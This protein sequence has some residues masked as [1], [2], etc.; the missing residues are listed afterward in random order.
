[1]VSVII[2]TKNEEKDLPACLESLCWCNDIHVV[3]SGSCDFT[4]QI[5]QSYRASVLINNFESFA[6]QRNWAIDHCAVKHDWILFLDADERSTPEFYS[7]LIFA[8]GSADHEVAGFYCCWKMILGT[9]WLKR[10]DNF[11]KWQFRILRRGRARFIDVGHGQKEGA[12]DGQIEYLREPYLHYAFSR[13]WQ[14]WMERHRRYARKEAAERFKNP[15]DLKKIFSLHGAK[16]NPAIKR[17]V[18]NLPIW[19][20]IRF[21]YSFVLNGGWLEG[22]EGLD[23]CW[24]IMWY[25]QEIQRE[26][27]CFYKE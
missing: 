11:P 17:L 1:M 10:A 12:V 19:P 6:Q 15:I 7:A 13:G 27:K 4:V 20:Q 23:Y 26:I 8:L 18:G 5:A 22:S 2:L 25:E 3:D 9:Q 16:R 14:T 21:F 24:K